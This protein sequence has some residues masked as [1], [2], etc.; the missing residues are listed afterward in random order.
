MQDKYAVWTGRFQPPHVGHFQL[1]KYSVESLGLPHVVIM[2]A[3]FNG[4]TEG[5]YGRL[6]QEAY[7]SDRNPFTVWE[8]LALMRL[9]L[10][11]YDLVDQTTVLV[12]PH[13]DADW[14]YVSTF[15][16]PRRVICLTAKDE[17]EA[18]KAAL[19]RSRGERVHVFSELGPGSVVTTTWIQQ[20]VS[21]GSDW[22]DFMPLKSHNYFEEIDGPSRVF[23]ADRIVR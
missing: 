12:A 10:Q 13:H 19:W 5:F 9:G 3:Y 2:V 1:L 22:R 15:Y 8:R 16:P 4:E 23:G 18:A 11:E 14:S 21:T 6:A 20:M 7:S 17:F